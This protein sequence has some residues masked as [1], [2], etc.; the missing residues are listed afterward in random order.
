VER[1]TDGIDDT[2]VREKKR[3]TGRER[4]EREKAKRE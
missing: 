3:D 1:T 2:D 4:G